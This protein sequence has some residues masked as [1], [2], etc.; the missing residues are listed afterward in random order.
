MRNSIDQNLMHVLSERMQLFAQ[1]HFRSFNDIVGDKYI[2]GQYIAIPLT[3]DELSYCD[4]PGHI[5][6]D[7]GSGSSQRE[8]KYL[9]IRW[10]A[11]KIGNS[12]K[13]G[14]PQFLYDGDEWIELGHDKF[15]SLGRPTIRYWDLFHP[16]SMY[17]FASLIRQLLAR[18]ERNKM[19]A[20]IKK[21]DE[22]WTALIWEN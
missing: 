7:Y 16:F 13:R 20:E 12:S 21:L 9:L 22:L 14:L 5:G 4:K 15:D 2:D 8:W 11:V 1:I 3:E 19:Y 17:G 6:F 18:K 10:M